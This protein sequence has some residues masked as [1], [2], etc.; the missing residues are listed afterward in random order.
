[1]AQAPSNTSLIDKVALELKKATS[2]GVDP[3]DI[4][5]LTLGGQTRTDVGVA[6]RIGPFEVVRADDPLAGQ[7]VIA[8]TF[9]RFKGLERPWIIVTELTRAT[10]RYDVRMHV[11]LTRATVSCVVVATHEEVRGDPRLAAV[12]G[13]SG[14]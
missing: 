8:D 4:A 12:A 3:G 7:H 14:R 13:A 6:D 2:A 9:L 10:D 1:V 5:V 11:A